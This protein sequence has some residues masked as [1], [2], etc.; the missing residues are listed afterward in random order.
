MQREKNIDLL[1]KGIK[2]YSI[3]DLE[4]KINMFPNFWSVY[5][6]IYIYICIY[7]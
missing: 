2:R 4:K 6:Y 7:I 1:F 5:I 3:F